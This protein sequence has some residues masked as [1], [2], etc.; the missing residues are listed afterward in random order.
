MLNSKEYTILKE[1]QQVISIFEITIRLF[2][3]IVLAMLAAFPGGIVHAQ[4]NT[5]EDKAQKMLATMTPEEKVG[6][7]FL[8]TFQDSDV[9]E[10]SQIYDLILRKHIGGVVLHSDHNNFTAN[11]ITDATLLIDKLQSIKPGVQTVDAETN[12]GRYIPLFIGLSQDGDG[13]PNDQIADGL[14]K[15]PS[16]MM[17]GATW[18]TQQAYDVG[19][20]LG[21][22]LSLLGVNLLVGPSLDVL[23]SPDAEESDNL[24]VRSFG[25]DPYWV[26]VM[27]QSYISGIHSGSNQKVVVISKH[28]P[29]RGAADRPLESEVAT[30]RKSLEQL[31]QIELAPFFAVTN[32]D[33][34]SMVTDGLMVS[35]LRYQGFQGNIRATT[36][37]VSLDSTALLQILALPEFT[38]WREAGGVMMSDDLGS[39][40][41]RRFTDSSLQNFDTRQMARNAFL[42]GNDLLYVDNFKGTG[43]EDSFTGIVNT[44]EFFAQKYNQD[45]AFAERVNQSVLRILI[46][47]YKLYPSF[48]LSQVLS[49]GTSDA[50]IGQQA[51]LDYV[52]AQEA[53]TLIDPTPSELASVIP[54]PPARNERIIFLMD[55][56]KVRQCS[57]CDEISLPAGD[58]FQKAVLT[59]FGP[60]TGNQVVSSR[61]S[62]YSFQSVLD[63]L[64]DINPPKTLESDLRNAD[65]I[66]VGTLNLDENRPSSYAFKRLLS[67]KPDLFRNKKVIVFSFNAPYYLDATD[68]S[69]ISAYYGI[70]GKSENS[71]KVAA[72][73]LFQEITPKGASPV[74]IPGVGYDLIQAT[75]PD[76]A[77]VIQLMLD[78]PEIKLVSP[79]NP[80]I[81]T[82]PNTLPEFRIGDM[83]PIR[84]GIIV[85]HNGHPVPDGTVTRFIITSGSDVSGT[86]QIEATTNNGIART[87]IRIN[88][89]GLLQVRVVSEPA[90]TSSILQLDVPP[91]AGAIIVE[92]TPMSIPSESPE[93]TVTQMLPSPTAAIEV[94]QETN[95]PVFSSWLLSILFIGLGSVLVYYTGKRMFSI[96]WGVRWALCSIISGLASYIYMTGGFPGGSSWLKLTGTAGLLGINILFIAFGWAI[97]ILWHSLAARDNRIF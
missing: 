65:W 35:N 77:Q 95:K 21:E 86:Q 71:I 92:V 25:G 33:D 55:T 13:L 8:V 26:G 88:S 45:S 72:L 6:Q 87:S 60:N 1:N 49:S 10:E 53:A 32:T 89:K 63:W 90:Q 80:Q 75:S 16:Q 40:A 78:L 14:T 76:P 36:K 22:D 47:K 29:G 68:I 9:S 66:V 19:A 15:I 34:K 27:G 5:P 31:K 94:V 56:M 44:L 69:K 62:S 7:L 97:G 83:L 64:N 52:V 20:A 4:A 54:D 41:I 23:E 3:I 51:G 24:G 37:P 93:P 30:V 18:N 73:I 96:R 61:L 74:S 79:I 59:S 42:A 84:T 67:E 70:Y 46:M 11:T 12:P 85:D 39:Q 57:T 2:I 81:T 91:D 28:F 17:I 50:Q 58:S 43:D 48:N 38:S 82:T